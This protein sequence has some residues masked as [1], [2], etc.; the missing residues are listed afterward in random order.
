MNKKSYIGYCGV[1]V[2]QEFSVYDLDI[3]NNPTAEDYGFLPGSLFEKSIGIGCVLVGLKNKTL[4]LRYPQGSS[5]PL[6]YLKKATEDL[7]VLAALLIS[8]LAPAGVFA[9]KLQEEFPQHE[10]AANIL[11]EWEKHYEQDSTR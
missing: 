7:K 11:R 9:D 6:I 8:G 2:K 4:R 1:G 10:E 3:I 5:S